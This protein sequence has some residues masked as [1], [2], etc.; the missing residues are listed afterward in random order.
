MRTSV[1]RAERRIPVT[2]EQV[3]RA[4]AALFHTRGFERTTMQEIARAVGLTKASLYHHVRGK[5]ALLYEILQHTLDRALPDLERIAAGAEP[6]AD[7]L[8]QAVRLHVLTLVSDRDNVACFI[9]EGRA[10]APPYRQALVAWRDRYEALFRRIIAD[11]IAAGE[12]APTDVRLAGF[13]VLGMVNWMVRWYR[14]D[15]QH[16]PAEIAARFADYAVAALRPL[17]TAAAHGARP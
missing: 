7:R 6:A 15:G 8:R 11:G 12:F 1:T 10:L 13:A 17:A 5:Q 3:L 14:P 4:A 16:P 9:E 2:R